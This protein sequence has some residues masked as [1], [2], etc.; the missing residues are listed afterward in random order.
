MDILADDVGGVL[1]A[2]K[3]GAVAQGAGVVAVL[4]L[5]AEIGAADAV[6]APEPG[7]AVSHCHAGVPLHARAVRIRHLHLARLR[8]T[9]ALAGAEA[10]AV[11]T[12]A[13]PVRADEGAVGNLTDAD[14][15]V[16]VVD[17]T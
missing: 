1:D 9:G 11:D 7:P 17:A 6:G 12:L 5:P 13:R 8:E 15:A 4:A 2:V 14:V 3:V 10:I 16:V